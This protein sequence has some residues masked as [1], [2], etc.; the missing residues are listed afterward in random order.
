MDLAL[1]ALS[2]ACFSVI[3]DPL[4]ALIPRRNSAPYA[5]VR[6]L[7]GRGKAGR[8]PLGGEESRRLLRGGAE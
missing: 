6:V 7:I 3:R 8:L 4:A 1:A 5:F 2:S